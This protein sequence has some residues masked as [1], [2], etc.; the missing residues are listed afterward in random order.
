MM[1]SVQQLTDNNHK[2][3]ILVDLQPDKTFLKSRFN[4]EFK[5]ILKLK[6]SV[7]KMPVLTLS[8]RRL[9]SAATWYFETKPS[10][11]KLDHYTPSSLF[12]TIV[13]KPSSNEHSK[14]KHKQ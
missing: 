4:G 3:L 11:K 6:F 5:K 2:H 8:Q 12:L 1:W 7:I 14:Y 9:M 13:I 10:Q